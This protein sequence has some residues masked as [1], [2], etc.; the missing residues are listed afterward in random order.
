M[1]LFYDPDR[2][3]G[4]KPGNLQFERVAE[5]IG[6]WV[7]GLNASGRE[8]LSRGSRHYLQ[9]VARDVWMDREVQMTS[10]VNWSA[11]FSEES[12]LRNSTI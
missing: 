6:E 4:G 10:V 8:A 5:R 1:P 9:N 11:G 7:H 3:R 2:S 12:A